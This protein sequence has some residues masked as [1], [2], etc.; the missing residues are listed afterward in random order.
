[1]HPSPLPLPALL[2]LAAAWCP[3]WCT[4]GAVAVL[5]VGVGALLFL[6]ALP[7]AGP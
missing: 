6:W 5:V 7:E 3:W 2:T 1:M 4:A